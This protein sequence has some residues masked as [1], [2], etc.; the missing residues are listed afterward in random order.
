MHC[1]NQMRVQI[2]PKDNIVLITPVLRIF[3]FF[4]AY[5]KSLIA[6]YL[7]SRGTQKMTIGSIKK[8]N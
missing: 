8:Y 6:G 2:P 5:F 1:P 7:A 3:Y 4:N